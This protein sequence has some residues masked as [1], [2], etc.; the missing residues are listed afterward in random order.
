VELISFVT[1]LQISGPTFAAMLFGF[2]LLWNA[3][4][5]RSSEILEPTRSM[6]RLEG[7]LAGLDARLARLEGAIDRLDDRIDKLSAAVDKL[8]DRVALAF[9]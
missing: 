9:S 7:S 4:Q 8:A 6:G 3:Q 5:A 2:F 1:W